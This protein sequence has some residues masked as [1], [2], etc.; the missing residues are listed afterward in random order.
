[1]L[2][3]WEVGRESPERVKDIFWRQVSE[4]APREYA[5]R[6]FDAAS[7]EAE[8]L[9]ALIDRHLKHWRVKRL[10]SVDRNL[11]RLAITEFRHSPEIAPPVVINEALEMAKV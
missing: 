5:D 7:A 8:D 9:D 6:L 1:M 3:Q 11:L 4:Q 2:Y 10:A